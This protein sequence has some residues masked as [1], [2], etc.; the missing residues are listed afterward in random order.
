MVIIREG[1][2]ACRWVQTCRVLRFLCL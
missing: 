2:S 1:S